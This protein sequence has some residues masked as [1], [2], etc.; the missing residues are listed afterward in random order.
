MSSPVQNSSVS[1]KKIENQ[2][3]HMPSPKEYSLSWV[4]F[5][6][7]IGSFCIGT[8]EFLAMGLIQEISHGLDVSVTSAGHFISAYALGV[9]IGAPVIAIL[10]AKAPRKIMLMGLMLFYALANFATV[11]VK[12]P[13]FML[14]SRFVAGLPHGAYFGIGALVVAQLA[15]PSKRSSAIAKMMMGLTLAN[16]LGVPLGTW[17][18]QQFGWQAGFELSAAIALLTLAAV[19]FFVPKTPTPSSASVR[20]ELAG[21]KNIDMWLTLS[22]GAIGFGGMFAVYSYASPMLTNYTGA[23]ITVVPFALAIFGVG[24]VCG[25]LIAGWF[26]DKS[27]NKTIVGILVCSA[28]AFV[29][30]HFLISHLYTAML[31]FFL[32][33]IT[34]TGLAN[35]IQVRLMD[36]AGNAQTLAASLN[37]SA[38]NVANALGAFLGGWVIDHQLGWISP[39]WVGFGLS[40]VGLMMFWIS[41]RYHQLQLQ[42]A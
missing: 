36:V 6:L 14:I 7:A 11:W 24:M 3:S 34:V 9:T 19:A 2:P 17:L 4:I 10:A 26:A 31:A 32:I 39:I 41:N 38:F 42:K 18:G 20:S 12:T 15:G 40:L 1:T 29:I 22:V 37:H 21:L 13:E 16:V 5:A 8:T 30:S 25:G 35:T 28:C 27:L 33:G 23:D